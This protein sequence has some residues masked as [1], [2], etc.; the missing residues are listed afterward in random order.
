[1]HAM[2]QL[3]L[4][5]LKLISHILTCNLAPN[6]VHTQKRS[7]KVHR[8]WELA[9]IAN[10]GV[11]RWRRKPWCSFNESA[12]MRHFLWAHLSVARTP[13]SPLCA[14]HI[15]SI[16]E[17]K[18]TNKAVHLYGLLVQFPMCMMSLSSRFPGSCETV[19]D[20]SLEAVGIG[21]SV[22]LDYKLS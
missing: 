11:W 21:Q 4:V 1:M 7:A 14:M 12:V 13:T 9:K 19:T 17:G 2:R 22:S 18:V 10:K 20:D 16:T 6:A 5:R 8:R 15:L 3:F